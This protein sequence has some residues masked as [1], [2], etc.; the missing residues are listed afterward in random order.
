MKFIS[1]RDKNRVVSFK[2]AV[3]QGLSPEGGLFVPDSVP[4][5]SQLFAGMTA[6]TPFNEAASALTAAILKD[7]LS[8]DRA[9]KI[10]ERA[11]FFK[12][13]L[14]DTGNGIFI[15]ELF[16]GPSS[17][18][19]DFGACF[20]AASMEEF[21]QAENRRAIILTAT[22]GD[23]GSAVAQAF[24][25]KKNID[26]VILYPSGRVSPLQ[27]KQLTTLGKNV[28]AVE[29]KG[30]FD[31]CQRMVKETFVSQDMKYLPLT[32][33]NSI[34]LGR[35]FP[36]SFYYMYGFNQLKAKYKNI[37]FCV[38]SGNFGNL[39]AGVYAWKWGLP[40][41]EFIAATN[42]NNEVPLYLESGK[43]EPHPSFRTYSNAMDVGD[44]SNFERLKNIFNNDYKE[45]GRWIKGA[46]VSN[47]DTLQA[48]KDFYAEKKKF[49][50]PHTA[51]GYVASSRYMAANKP[52]DT[53]II[54]LSTAHPGKFLEVVEQATGA[55]PALPPNLEKLL[56]LEKKSVVI[57]NNSATLKEFLKKNY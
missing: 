22:S 12:P 19:K 13:E 26:V 25:N 43:Y 3:F 9:A 54:T 4:D 16:H 21:L 18:F 47:E 55:R 24:F 40:V 11:F 15:E 8:P 33:A 49:I 23:T 37:I 7:E 53:A 17:A 42:L 50:D 27:E 32:S 28:T 5:L 2:E 52:E 6:E 38:P 31:D 46:W 10:C 51:V 44:P 39:T 20:L 29:V 45:M 14:V 30:N 56:K 35:L 36:Q 41:K 34:N 57:D 1:T 48:I